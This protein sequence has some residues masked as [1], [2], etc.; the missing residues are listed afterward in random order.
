MTSGGYNILPIVII[1]DTLYHQLPSKIL[2]ARHTHNTGAPKLHLS[3]T[4]QD[5]ILGELWGSNL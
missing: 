1:K 4:Q 2:S 5:I 3:Q